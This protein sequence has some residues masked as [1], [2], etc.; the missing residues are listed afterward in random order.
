[1][2]VMHLHVADGKRNN[3]CLAEIRNAKNRGYSDCCKYEVPKVETLVI[4]SAYGASGDH[5]PSRQA[6]QKRVARWWSYAESI[7]K[8]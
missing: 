3:M 5:Q 2:T 6:N 7:A 8:R 1:M 4:E